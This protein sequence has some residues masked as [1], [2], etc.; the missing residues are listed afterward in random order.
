MDGPTEPSPEA[1]TARRRT[2]RYIAAAM[3]AV[4]SAIYFLIGFQVVAVVEQVTEQALFGIPA[5]I[6][7][8]LAALALVRFDNRAVWAVGA[9]VQA[10]IILMYIGASEQRTPPFEMWGLLIRVAQ[11][12][13]LAALVILALRPIEHRPAH[14]A[15]PA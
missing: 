12:M 14:P 1:L 15:V 9:I 13:L 3:A 10:L 6:G 4:A 7:F 5:G 8:G 2:I 11:A